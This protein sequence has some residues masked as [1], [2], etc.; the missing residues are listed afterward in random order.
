MTKYLAISDDGLVRMAFQAS[1]SSMAMYRAL[2]WLSDRT[3]E[4]LD[5][6][7]LRPE[8]IAYRM[9]DQSNGYYWQES[10]D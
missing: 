9:G 8:H 5:V 7:G 1:T 6:D 10:E 2:D 4:L 3:G